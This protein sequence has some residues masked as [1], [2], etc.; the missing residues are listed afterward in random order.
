MG[1]AAQL[2]DV[3]EMLEVSM[4]IGN[5]AADNAPIAFDSFWL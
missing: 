5:E 1:I 4:E 2:R 3:V